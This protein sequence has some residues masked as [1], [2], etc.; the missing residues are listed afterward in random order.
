MKQSRAAR[1]KRCGKQSDAVTV[2]DGRSTHARQNGTRLRAHQTDAHLGGDLHDSIKPA[3]EFRRRSDNLTTTLRQ[4]FIAD[5]VRFQIPGQNAPVELRPARAR[6]A[7]H[8]AQESDVM[9]L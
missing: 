1:T 2:S 9:L 3:R 6:E 8:V 5:A 7:S 4:M